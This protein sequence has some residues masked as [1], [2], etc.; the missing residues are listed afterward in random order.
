MRVPALE[1]VKSLKAVGTL[2][3]CFTQKTLVFFV[4]YNPGS[5][6]IGFAL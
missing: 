6:I 2:R 3:L 1:P 4:I 5:T